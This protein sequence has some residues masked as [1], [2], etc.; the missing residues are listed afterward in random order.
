MKV[1]IFTDVHGNKEALQAILSDIKNKD[2]DEAICLG[3][4]IAIGPNSKEWLDMIID[5]NVSM[6]LGN[7]E[8]YYLKGI[9][10][11]TDANEGLIKYYGWFKDRLPDYQREYL[12]KLGLT[13]EKD[14]NGKKVLFEHF[15]INY[16]CD[17][18]Y[19]FY[20]LEVD[21]SLVMDKV[22]ASLDYDLI[23]V[24]HEHTEFV[25]DKIYDVGSAGCTKDSYTKYAIL[26]TDNFNIEKVILNYDRNSFI[27]DIK[28]ADYPNKDVIAKVIFGIDL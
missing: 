23:F 12:S 18:E 20:D 13:I 24:G 19:P 4:V 6:V 2:I 8:L 26:D 28:N 16:N 11:E 1:A 10:I 27:E 15:P 7:H 22:V 25:Y 14:F 21:N 17:E 5:N 3:D 9:E